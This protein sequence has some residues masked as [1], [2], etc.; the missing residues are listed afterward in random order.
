MSIFGDILG[1]VL[2][3]MGQE[4]ANDQSQHNAE[5]QMSFQERMSSTAYQRATADMQAAGLNPM[6]AYQQ[7]GASS[8]QG[9]QAQVGNSLGAAV[10]SAGQAA[11]IS[12]TKAQTEQTKAQT[13]QTQAETARIISETMDQKLNSAYLQSKIDQALSGAGNTQQDTANK[14]ADHGR[15][16]AGSETAREL[17]NAMRTGDGFSAVVSDLV[18][19]G[20]Q[21]MTQAGKSRATFESDVAQ[22]KAES[23]LTQ[24]D[25]PRAKSEQQ[26]FEGIGQANPFIRQLLQLFQGLRAISPSR[27]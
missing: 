6:L 27:R 13:G 26:F 7:G 16:Q 1:P 5:A 20:D 15:I 25:I 21:S 23:T 24:M 18:G 10:A 14:A 3:Y 8:P 2:G 19:K 9:A 4:N 11:Q 22:R 17:L 12:Q